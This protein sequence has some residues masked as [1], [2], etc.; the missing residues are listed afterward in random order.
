MNHRKIPSQDLKLPEDLRGS[1]RDT[2]GVL[3]EGELPFEYQKG[4]PLIAVGDVVTDTLVH[5]NVIPDVAMVDGM[6]R[7]GVYESKMDYPF[8]IV[9]LKNSTGTISKDAWNVI[10]DAINETEP[11]LI[12]VDGEEDLL[13]IPSIILCPD[14]GTVIYGIPSKGMVVNLVDDTK[15]E[16]CWNVIDKMKEL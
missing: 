7:R 14:G 2:L 11:V 3:V 9:R 5:Q 1:L 13:S 8:K 15:K 16:E 12:D 10:Q 4:R 6:T